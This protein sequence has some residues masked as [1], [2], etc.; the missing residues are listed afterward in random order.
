MK[1]VYKLLIIALCGWFALA[2]LREGA[3]I[4][5]F[6]RGIGLLPPIRLEYEAKIAFAFMEYL[7]ITN[8]SD[9]P[10]QPTSI[11][12]TTRKGVKQM[13]DAPAVIK[14]H[15]MVKIR[16]WEKGTFFDGNFVFREGDEIQVYCKGYLMPRLLSF[17]K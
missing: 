2:V 13:I 16:L 17:E 6:L 8:T 9:K 5:G 10:V 12:V 3:V 15:D 1:K 14:E 7:V 4:R 11:M